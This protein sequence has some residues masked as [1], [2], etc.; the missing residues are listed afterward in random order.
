MEGSSWAT[1]GQLLRSSWTNL[2]EV[3]V[4]YLGDC[5]KVGLK[6]GVWVVCLRAVIGRL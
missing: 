1:P 4:N 5:V 3:L 2:G 6:D